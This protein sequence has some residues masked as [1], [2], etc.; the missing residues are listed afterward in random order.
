MSGRWLGVS[1]PSADTTTMRNISHRAPPHDVSGGLPRWA[2]R[3]GRLARSRHP[4]V[5]GGPVPAD[6][7]HTIGD[8]TE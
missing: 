4:E 2:A 7:R 6:C 8:T 5:S 3:P 1:T